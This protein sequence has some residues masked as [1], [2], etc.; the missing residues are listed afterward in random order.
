MGLPLKHVHASTVSRWLLRLA[1]DGMGCAWILSNP[2]R[3]ASFFAALNGRVAWAAEFLALG[4]SDGASAGGVKINEAAFAKWKKEGTHPFH[5][6]LTEGYLESLWQGTRL[7]GRIRNNPLLFLE[8]VQKL[9]QQHLTDH[10]PKEPVDG[11]EVQPSSDPTLF[12]LN[13]MLLD[14]FLE[15]SPI[16]KEV[17]ELSFLLAE[18]DGIRLLFD[19]I[20][21]EPRVA[22][23]FTPVVLG[24]S[25][26][27]WYELSS[28][29]GRL[30]ISRMVTV[31]PATRR[32][33]AMSEFWHAWFT[34]L[35]PSTGDLFSQLVVPLKP[36]TNAGALGRLAP[37]DQEI[38]RDVLERAT[39]DHRG[40]NVLLYGARSVDVSGTVHRLLTE[41]EKKAY[42]LASDIP[43]TD[44][45][46][47]CYLAQ[48]Y[49]ARL[50]R[51]GVLVL[52]SADQVLTRTRRGLRQF[53]FVTVEM[54]DDT[55]D[56][57]SERVLLEEGPSPCIWLIHN[58][59]RLSEDNLARFLYTC[60]VK[61]AS[62]AERKQGI[63]DALAGLDLRPE[64]C[65]ELSQ[66][67]QLGSKQLTSAARL[68]LWLSEQPDPRRPLVFQAAQSNSERQELLVRRAIDQSQKA[69][70]RRQREVLNRPIT[71][72]SLDFLNISGSITVPQIL[73][74][75]K[76][77]PSATLCFWGQPGTGKTQLAEMLAVEVDKPL[78]SRR[79][80]DLLDKYVGGSERLIR[81]MFEEGA[82]T[83]S[84]LFLDE[85]DSFLRN[86]SFA[87][88]QWEVSIVNELLQGME[89]FPGIF[90][91]ATN[92]FRN[93]DTA[94]MRR[95]TFKVE[96]KPLTD[97][98]KWR[99][100]VNE[101]GIDT[102]RTDLDEIRARLSTVPFVTPGDFATIQR[103]CKRLDIRMSPDEWITA[104]LNEVTAKA[105][106]METEERALMQP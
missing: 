97:D 29:Q 36:K 25:M 90:V 46:S 12:G 55:H 19:L 17:L 50:D 35:A 14:P 101:T 102:A 87:R 86:R 105:M 57:E 42:T 67:A 81:T 98:Q 76:R 16:E 96:F 44:Q 95:F 79:A 92:L 106:A 31:Q 63:N 103:Q 32:V 43:A 80:S 3:F 73:A 33:L 6:R 77:Q 66:H 9:V 28:Q 51:A 2:Q 20:A 8:A 27:E 1:K 70:N 62:R 41:A 59:E 7:Y 45:A 72:Y 21:E 88:H 34:R 78:L 30:S 58:P 93:L 24:L 100:F 84:V 94:A 64:F 71:Q 40:V 22:A 52:P 68:A 5:G 83:D 10:I 23:E 69:L 74:S 4:E 104:L 85:A 65:A 53:L 37:E 99:M 47:V 48:R 56:N 18:D 39:P 91:C 49:V 82:D 13:L 61:P 75:L 89:R 38:V 15:F 11:N 54:E 26:D 60:E